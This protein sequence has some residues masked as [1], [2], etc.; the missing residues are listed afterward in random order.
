MGQLVGSQLGGEMVVCRGPDLAG[1]SGEAVA[2]RPDGFVKHHRGGS[3]APRPLPKG[4]GG[5]GP[6]LWPWGDRMSMERGGR[7]EGGQGARGGC[8]LGRMKVVAL[9][10]AL[11]KTKERA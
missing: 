10:P 3:R 8:W 4:A 11:A 5:G 7:G 1:G 2:R 6:G 9:G